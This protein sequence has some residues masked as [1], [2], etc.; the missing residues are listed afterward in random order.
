MWRSDDRSYLER[1]SSGRA[2][3]RWNWVGTMCDVVTLYC[4]I[5]CS[6]CSGSHLSIS[7]TVWP[8]LIDAPEKRSTAVW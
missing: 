6:M 7:T 1:T 3:S 5:S 2:S 4:S 8:K